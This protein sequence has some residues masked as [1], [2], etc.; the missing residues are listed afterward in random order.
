MY[1][2]HYRQCRLRVRELVGALGEIV[3]AQRVPA[4]PQ[5]TI[6][7]L[8]AHQAGMAADFASAS[9]TGWPGDE[10]A[11]AQVSARISATVDEL[12]REW[13]QHAAAVEGALH[14][15]EGLVMMHDALCH[16]ADLRG[17]LRLGRPPREAWL[18][19]LTELLKDFD[20]RNDAGRLVV[21]TDEETYEAGPGEPVTT[22]E[23]H[24]YEL[25]RGMLGRRSQ[26]QMAD[27]S[28]LPDAGRYTGLLPVMS[29]VAAPLA[30]PV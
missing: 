7:E 1:D 6:L 28:W 30:E 11:N 16:E 23:V 5:W 22:L 17:A 10:Q 2:Q 9:I 19:S 21:H 24:A 14:T 13:E 18:A 29:P 25:W 12:I 15:G 26:G 20:H 27:W 8:L 4:C 3:L